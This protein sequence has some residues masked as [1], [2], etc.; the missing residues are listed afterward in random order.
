MSSSSRTRGAAGRVT[1]QAV[2]GKGVCVEGEDRRS[3]RGSTRG[4]TSCVTRAAENQEVHYCC[5]VAFG[6]FA[7]KPVIC[8]TA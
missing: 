6:W 2:E 3:V 7:R 4:A 8:F 5:V 1:G